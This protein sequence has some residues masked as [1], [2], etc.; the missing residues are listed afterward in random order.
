MKD[1][2]E[3]VAFLDQWGCFQKAV[4]FLLCASIIPNGFGA[5]N[6]VFLTD[7]PDHHCFVP[8]LNFSEEWRKSIIP[9]TVLNGKQELSRC[10][11]YR[12]DVVQNLSDRGFIPGRDVN[13]TDLEE[14]RCVD[15]WSYSTDVYLSTVVT[16]VNAIFFLVFVLPT[17]IFETYSVS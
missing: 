9:K 4:F 13:L 1:Y 5:F 2:E 7:V 16:E 6:L 11:R 8:D 12:L 14:E 10:S 3:I 15:G 17:F